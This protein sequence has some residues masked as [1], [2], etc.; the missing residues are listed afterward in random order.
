MEATRKS[1]VL[2]QFSW[3]KFF[4][5]ESQKS[6]VELDKSDDQFLESNDEVFENNLYSARENVLMNRASDNIFLKM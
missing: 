1:N 6:R 5:E 2:G 3:K 4:S